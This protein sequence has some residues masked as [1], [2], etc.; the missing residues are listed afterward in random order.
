MKKLGLI[1]A[2]LLS[3]AAVMVLY[4]GASM[5]AQKDTDAL[6]LFHRYDEQS[7]SHWLHVLNAATGEEQQLSELIL[8]ADAGW[9]PDG[10]IWAVDTV[11]AGEGRLRFFDAKTGEESIFGESLYL[12]GCFPPLAWSPGGEDFVYLT[13]TEPPFSLHIL[14]GEASHTIPTEWV[15]M[16]RW[17]PDGRYLL[18]I[19]SP[20]SNEASV[21]AAEGASEVFRGT[22]LRLYYSSFSPDSRYLA[23][24]DET[25]TPWLLELATSESTQ[26]TGPADY[27]RWSSSGRYLLM[28]NFSPTESVVYYDTETGEEHQLEMAYPV[29]FTK[30]TEDETVMLLYTDFTDYSGDLR[31][32]TLLSYDLARGEVE[33]IFQT[34][35][36][37][38]GFSKLGNWIAVL[39]STTAPADHYAPTTNA[40]FSNGE[41]PV[42]AELTVDSEYRVSWSGDGRW[43]TIDAHE[44]LYRFDTSDNSLEIL[45]SPDEDMITPVKSP[46]GD[47]LAFLT[48]GSQLN[49]RNA[50]GET[51]A[52]LPADEPFFTIIGWQYGSW[53]QSLLRCGIGQ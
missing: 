42:D 46:D 49:L 23:Y 19:D 31:P 13:G 33:T 1:L 41:T 38:G 5:M 9:S 40:I 51:I 34:T 28:E 44:G 36:W 30:W 47:Y 10:R 52:I 29:T 8:P 11:V 53:Q 15:E 32:Q 45:P 48:P 20:S 17:S 3:L 16:P 21:L 22:G 24:W 50:E 39:Y 37:I 7:K 18:L 35:G 26:L 6:L 12:N 4:L 14:R 2:G 27:F 25:E 43:I